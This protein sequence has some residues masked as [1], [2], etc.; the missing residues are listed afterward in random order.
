MNKNSLGLV[1]L[2]T[3]KAMGESCWRC[4]Q[5][6]KAQDWFEQSAYGEGLRNLASVMEY[7][8]SGY[9]ATNLHQC[10]SMSDCANGRIGDANVYLHVHN[11]M[12]IRKVES[13]LRSSNVLF[14]NHSEDE[15]IVMG[16]DFLSHGRLDDARDC[17]LSA[18]NADY[19]LECAYAYIEQERFRDA[20][21]LFDYLYVAI[22]EHRVIPL[23]I[24]WIRGG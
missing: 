21:W 9:R 16:I 7:C 3:A 13:C 10:D 4:N 11:L 17:F 14:N 24:K 6:E 23:A 5:L 20:Q 2:E 8:R 18:G 12:L 1:E 22:D 15:L 19:C